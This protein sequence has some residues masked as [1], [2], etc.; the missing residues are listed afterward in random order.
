MS[1]V[2][3]YIATFIALNAFACGGDKKG[4]GSEGQAQQTAKQASSSA[5]KEPQIKPALSVFEGAGPALV[6]PLAKLRFGM[7]R[8]EAEKVSR[9][10]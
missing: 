9:S 3:K 2:W 5:P 10:G 8:Q 6:N 1:K 7:S 4:A